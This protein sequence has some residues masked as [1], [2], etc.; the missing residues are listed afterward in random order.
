MAVKR[1]SGTFKTRNDVFDNITPNNI[2]VTP[3]G[4][5][6]VPAGEFKP[7][8]WLPIVWTGT[9]SQDYFVI[10][11]GKVVSMTSQGELVPSGI[12]LTSQAAASGGTV[13]T[14]TAADVT[15]GTIDIT[16]GEAVQ[17]AGARTLLQMA[18][19]I[20]ERGLV[21]AGRAA[22][23]SA[24]GDYTVGTVGDLRAV[25]ALYISSPVGVA[26]YDVYHWAGDAYD[27]E[28]G[29]NFVN[30]QK[31]HAVQFFTQA[32]MQVPVGGITAHAAVNLA[33]ATAYNPATVAHGSAFPT[34]QSVAG[35]LFI[36]STQLNAL[37]RYDDSTKP[38]LYV[39][40]GTAIM[41]WALQGDTEGG[42]LAPHTTRTPWADANGVLIAEKK[43]V[44]DLSVAGDYFIDAEAGVL[45]MFS[46]WSATG[47]GLG[48]MAATSV[49][50]S[51]FDNVAGASTSWQQVSAIGDLEPGDY[52]TFD[53]FS[54]FVRW[55]A[56]VA[57]ERGGDGL[58]ATDTEIM[59]TIGR[60][61]AVKE[62]PL[63][64]LDR[65]RTAF[66]GTS[67]GAS[68]QMPG[69]ATSG[70]TDLLTLSNETVAHKVAIINVSFV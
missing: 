54:N 12:L 59:R 56:G 64:L 40:A 60:V 63:G 14:Y 1:F 57:A 16:T 13:I 42:K 19:G 21:P 17:A 62:E 70:Y 26:A 10:S 36:T 69:S 44:G 9:A 35:G 50:Y 24:S 11:S 30:Y 48:G 25:L 6:A 23:A 67:F 34:G 29:L 53:E 68:M 39:A 51:Y 58:P 27:A 18:N 33:A 22:A 66:D 45:L 47:A 43:S 52:L 38:S 7:A 55:D 32:Q 61:I 15:A 8:N 3:S 49:T 5:I 28:G 31:Q 46:S 37:E 41:G 2:V 20:I 4:G 65:V